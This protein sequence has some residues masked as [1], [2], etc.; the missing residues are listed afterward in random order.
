M[1]PTSAPSSTPASAT[2]LAP[3]L[4]G[5]LAYLFGPVTG[6]FFLVVEKSNPFARKQIAASASVL[7]LAL[8]FAAPPLSAQSTLDRLKQKLL[9]KKDAIADSLS[10]VIIDKATGAVQCVLDNPAC[11][12]TA[13]G[14]G[15]N[16]KVVDANGQPVSAADS[17]RAVTKA[18]GVPPSLTAANAANAQN[19]QNAAPA[20]GGTGAAAPAVAPAF[21]EGVFLNYDFVPGDRVLFAEDFARDNPGD[22]PRRLELRYGNL[23]VA[24][25]QGQ[26]FLRTNTPSRVIVPLPEAVPQRF[27]FEADYN[28]GGGWAMNVHFA[29]PDAPGAPDLTLATFSPGGGGLDGAGVSSEAAVP[30]SAMRPLTHVAVMADGRYA[31]AYVNGVR[32]AN[33]PN[34]T[35]GRGKVIVITLVADESTP[36]YIT[37]IR[38]AAGGKPLY[39]AIMADGRVATHGILFDVGSDRIRGESKPTL[40]QIGQMLQQHTDLKLTIEGHTD[41]VGNAASNQTLSDKRAAAVRAFLVANYGVDGSRLASKGLGA[42]KPAAPNDTP[43]GRQQNRRVEL[44][45]M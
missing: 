44:V 21:G 39:D 12:K 30:D 31:K 34:A 10:N 1:P 2:G 16:V 24:D 14:A 18:G 15:K 33:V 40:D 35:L 41:N 19:A 20:S 17:A 43:E 45:R 26:R 27:T 38:V 3:N 5:A 23:E 42:T 28:G 36:A 8:L 4:A 25:W 32:V 9:D 6:I 7:A 22:F 37:N 13:F 11:I 29:D